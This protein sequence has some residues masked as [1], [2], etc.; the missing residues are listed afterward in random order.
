[1]IKKIL[2]I[3]YRIMYKSNATSKKANFIYKL[4]TK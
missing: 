4:I 3:Y 2:T 1:M